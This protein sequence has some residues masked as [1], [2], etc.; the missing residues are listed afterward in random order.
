MLVPP[1]GNGAKWCGAHGGSS[2]YD[3]AVTPASAQSGIEMSDEMKIRAGRLV[4]REVS[5]GRA[6]DGAD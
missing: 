6:G 4:E 2:V 5:K 3:C 1:G